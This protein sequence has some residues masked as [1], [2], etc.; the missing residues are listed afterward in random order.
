[1]RFASFNDDLESFCCKM[2][3]NKLEGKIETDKFCRNYIPFCILCGI[4][5]YS[6]VHYSYLFRAS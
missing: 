3:A 6:I 5:F 4:L 1:M 2:K